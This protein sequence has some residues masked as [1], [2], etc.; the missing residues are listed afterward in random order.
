MESGESTSSAM[1]EQKLPARHQADGNGIRDDH[2]AHSRVEAYPNPPY[3]I[4]NP[5]TKIARAV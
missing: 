2:D 3:P 5:K 1:K 4:L